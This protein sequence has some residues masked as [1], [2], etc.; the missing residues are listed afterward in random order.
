MTLLVRVESL[1]KSR[2][3]ISMFKNLQS[4]PIYY[5]TMNSVLVYKNIAIFVL[6]FKFNCIHITTIN[7]PKSEYDDAD[8]I[9]INK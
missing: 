8:I 9:I 3:L 2:I 7:Y 1:V 5:K 4:L 6:R